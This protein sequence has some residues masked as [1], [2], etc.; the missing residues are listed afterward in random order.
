MPDSLDILLPY[1]REWIADRAPVKVYEKSRRIG[2][3]WTEAADCALSA[4]TAGVA[5]DDVSYVGYNREMAREFIDDCAFWA[6]RI[7][8]AAATIN[9]EVIH[10]EARDILAYRID[11]AS[12]H[13]IQALSSRPSNLRGREGIA[14]IDEAAFHD[15]LPELLKA[16]L[17]FLIWGGR[18][19]VIST[20]NGADNPFN[21]L[22]TDIRSGRKSYSLHRTDF[23]EA[24]GEGLFRRICERKGDPWSAANEAGWRAE[25]LELYRDN[26]EEELGCI[27]RRG[28]GAYLPSALVESRMSPDIPIVRWTFPQALMDRDA[29]VRY[30]AAADFCEERVRPA[31]ARLDPRLMSVFGEDFGRAPDGDLTVIWPLQIGQGL[32]RRTPFLLEL[33]GVPFKEQEQILFYVLDRLPRLVAGAM[34]ARGNG[35]YL[36]EQAAL[37]YGGDV[38]QQVML[39]VEWYREQ[40]PRYKR[41]F[42][43]G[44][45]ELPRDPDVLADH[46]LVV[47]ERGVAQVPQR[48]SRGESGAMRHGDSAIAGALAYYASTLDPP[49]YRGYTPAPRSRP[50]AEGDPEDDDRAPEASNRVRRFRAF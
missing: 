39:S 32:V 30:R 43:D 21:D 40:M 29:Y 35:S 6:L 26:A 17:A 2:I 33:S 48:R 44:L 5:G 42:E 24:V 38:V 49:S 19:R 1:Q 23:D 14:V 45:V 15:D 18:V 20:H 37:K 4:G 11:F 34:D 7:H 46:R 50:F 36:A 31:L 22:V 13:K 41:A 10:D 27:P 47:M 8:R 9:E 16:A 28:G 3:S 12:G 25:I